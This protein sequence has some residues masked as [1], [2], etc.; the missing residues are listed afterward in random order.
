M[1]NVL[2]LI[3]ACFLSVSAFASGDVEV[4]SLT[5]DK[6]S[7]QTGEDFTLTIRLRNNGPDAVN[8]VNLNFRVEPD[9]IFVLS[10]VAAPGWQCSPV[11]PSCFTES[12]PPGADVNLALHLLA[13][14]NFR[15]LPLSLRSFV[16]ST[17]DGNLGNGSATLEIPLQ[18]SNH[19]A[20]LSLSVSAPPDP[21]ALDTLL[22]LTYDVRNNGPQDLLDVRVFVFVPLTTPTA[23]VFQGAGW[24]CTP[25]DGGF[26]AT[27]RRDLLAANANAPL[28][29]RFTGP[30]AGIEVST[31]ASVFSAQAHLDTNLSNDDAYRTLSFGNAG[32][33]S[34]ILVPFAAS[35]LPGASG[36]LWKTEISGIIESDTLPALSASG[37]G[38]LEDPCSPPPLNRLFDAAAEDLVF[39][40]LGPQFLYVGREDAAKVKLAT[41]VYDVSKS[42]TTAGAFIPM[43]RDEDFST[44]GFS[45][46]AIPVAPQFRSTLR[47]YD[48]TGAAG[49]DVELTLYG[50]AEDVPFLHT[51]V[52]LFTIDG[53][54]QATTALL[55]LYPASAQVNLSSLVPA[56]YTRVRVSARPLL[57]NQAPFEPMQLWGFVSITNNQTSHVTVV[58]P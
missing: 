17:N 42:V 47:L 13:P 39:D 24:T 15:S 40:T 9:P 25:H 4:V 58:A 8:D 50:D 43:A 52:R 19:A 33:W 44:E 14:A 46:I 6:T 34:R 3:L 31:R 45:L 56:L 1:R 53:Q 11:F 37:C 7:L 23:K 28:S 20:D 55:P 27:C 21:I 2:V 30:A 57:P 54:G 35:E 41:R 10:S 49:R 22:T 48:A 26:A 32:D 36:S 16:G 51:V 5:A 38:G 12:M 29:V 18:A